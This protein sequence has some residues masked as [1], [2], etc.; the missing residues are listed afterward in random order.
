MFNEV[1]CCRI[2]AKEA[3]WKISGSSSWVMSRVFEG[4]AGCE[5]G[6]RDVKSMESGV[7]DRCSDKDF[8]VDGIEVGGEGRAH[9]GVSTDSGSIEIPAIRGTW[10][11]KD[12]G[13]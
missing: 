3:G 9:V 10:N 5:S 13:V 1:I 4:G 7:L 11:E 12:L 6:G 8:G 2:V